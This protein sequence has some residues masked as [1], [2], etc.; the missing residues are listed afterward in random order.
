M[1]DY[2]ATRWYRAPELLMGSREYSKEVDM[3]ALGCMIGEMFNG[4]AMF[5][6]NSTINQIERVLAWT[7][8]PSPSELKH[9]SSAGGSQSML[10]L[11]TTRRKPNQHDFFVQRPPHQCL[12]LIQKLLQFDPKKRYTIDQVLK[13]EYLAE[14]YNEKDL[15]EVKNMK[16]KI[17]LHINDNK[18]VSVKDYRELLYH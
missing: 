14:F 3:W 13:H 8:T 18:K 16:Q 11:L 4:K 7:G 2:I 10:H 1:T 12:S 17:H 9:L 5:P 6:G 15:R